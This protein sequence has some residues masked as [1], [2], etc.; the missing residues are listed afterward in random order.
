RRV[1]FRSGDTT[2][3]GQISRLAAP[4]FISQVSV[5]QYMA[6]GN[7]RQRAFIHAWQDL[8]DRDYLAFEGLVDHWGRYKAG[9]YRLKAY[10]TKTGAA[11]QLPPV[12]ILRPAALTRYNET[13]TYH[14]ILYHHQQWQLASAYRQP[15]L[16]FEWYLVR[17]DQWGNPV[18]MKHLGAGPQMRLQIPEDPSTCR[19]YLV[20]AREE[21]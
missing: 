18:A 8:G 15:G 20:A 21:A 3:V 4:W 9:Y 19:L 7:S 12:K 11:P 2:G 17:T 5:P 10:W 13:L 6:L 1:L 14:A 16:R